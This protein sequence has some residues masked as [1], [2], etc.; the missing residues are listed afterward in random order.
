MAGHLRSWNETPT[1]ASIVAF[2]ERAAEALPVEERVAV[3]SHDAAAE[4]GT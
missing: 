3:L 2:V 4:S 1:L